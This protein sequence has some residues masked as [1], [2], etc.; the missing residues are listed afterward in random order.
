M[1]SVYPY[2]SGSFYTASYAISSSYATSASYISYT[3]TAS[4]ALTVISPT[5]GSL[6]KSIC[7]ISTDMYSQMLNNINLVENCK[8]D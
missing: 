6:G 2:A 7:L 5:S 8:F 1:L 4:V 3:H